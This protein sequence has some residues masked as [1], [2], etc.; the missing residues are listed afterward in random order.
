[1]SLTLRDR[2][3]YR[4]DEEKNHA[5]LDDEEKR[6]LIAVRSCYP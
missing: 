6:R 2:R 1:M 5:M 3:S 4:D